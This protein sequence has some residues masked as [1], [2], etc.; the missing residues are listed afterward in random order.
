[1]K[2]TLAA[3][4]PQL[5]RHEGG[6]SNHRQDPGGATMS[7]VTQGTYDSW[8]A[9]QGLAARP[10]RQIGEDEVQ[11]IY[12]HHYWAVV[13]GDELPA[14]VDYSVFDAAVNSGPA[15]GAK[16]LQAALRLPQDGLIG[17]KTVAAA[18]IADPVALVNDICDVRLAFLKRLETWPI[19]GKGWNRRV[20]EVR[21][22][23]VE[24]AAAPQAAGKPVVPHP[25]DPGATMPATP[26]APAAGRPG[27]IAAAIAAFLTL[28]ARLFGARV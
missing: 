25:A 21:K 16:W 1:M 7:G 4:M 9:S 10:V 23:A 5:R 24:L 12:R 8:R 19:F 3:V 13:R 22:L 6:Y 11:A 2:A 14:G 27:G 20:A 28:I 26:A 18:A 17:P 15:R